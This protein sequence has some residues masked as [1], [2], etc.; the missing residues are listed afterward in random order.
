M[1]SK[2][3]P[4]GKAAILMPNGATTSNTKDDYKIRKAM[5]EAGKVEAILALPN[6]LFSNVT[7]SVQC[8]ILNK[9]KTNTD[10]LFVNADGLGK[11]ISRKIR[12]LED[13][14]I[15][16]VVKAY[17]DFR[18]GTLE[19]IPGFCKGATLEEII[20]KDYSLNPG[21]YVGADDSNKLTPEEIQEELRKA[22]AELLELMKEGKALE[23]KVK[24]ILMEELR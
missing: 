11:M 6:K 10:V 2:L 7:I 23:D 13:K 8:W 16:K 3:A 4:N 22:S 5:I 12:V 21:R 9:A 20:E 24:E 1:Y 17:R 18:N 15:S 19:D 14:D